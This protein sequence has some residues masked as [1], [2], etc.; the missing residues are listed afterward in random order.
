MSF[1]LLQETQNSLSALSI[2]AG[3]TA[4]TTL[5]DEWTN[6]PLRVAA[7]AHAR[8]VAYA[9]WA[10]Q[11]ARLGVLTRD[12]LRGDA[13]GLFL[14]GG[15]AEVQAQAKEYGITAA[16]VTAVARGTAGYFSAMVSESR[17]V[18]LG[19]V[20][21]VTGRGD[22]T[23]M[24]VAGGKAEV[25]AQAK[26]YGITAVEV[27]AVARGTA[28]YFSAMASET[29]GADLDIV[30][31]VT[32]RGDV[33]GMNVAGGKAEVQAQVQEYGITAAE[34]VQAARGTIAYSS[35]DRAEGLGIVSKVT[36]RGDGMGM[37]VAGGK[38]EVQAQALEH[39]ITAAEVVQAARGTIAF[40]HQPAAILAAALAGR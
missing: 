4:I 27:T 8:R 11:A 3:G 39:N 10:E 12:R 5:T 40:F 7:A 26:E 31:R 37:N 15:A 35:E 34:V 36:G 29:R 13:L 2:L 33:M 25:Q 22:G 9:L 32:G 30:S 14:A 21:K 23:G 28:G 1:E 19:I 6:N 18:D 17:A 38:A 20:S 24:N 16:E